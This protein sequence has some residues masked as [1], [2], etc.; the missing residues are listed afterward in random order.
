MRPL[1]IVARVGMGSRV[2]SH[3]GSRGGVHVDT[4]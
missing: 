2:G 4:K 1:G 3:G